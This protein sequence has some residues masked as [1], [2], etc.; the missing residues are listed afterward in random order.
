MAVGRLRGQFGICRD[1]VPFEP[2]TV[3]KTLSLSLVSCKVARR[4]I[5]P[6]RNARVKGDATDETHGR[7]H[8][9][10]KCKPIPASRAPQVTLAT[11]TNVSSM[12]FSPSE[13]V[14]EHKLTTNQNIRHPLE[15]EVSEPY[16]DDPRGH[17][18][19]SIDQI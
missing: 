3:W 17:S 8:R 11:D 7:Y 15:M 2:G 19:P 14:E 13:G 10:Q 4:V 18:Y 5:V 16:I 6:R 9:G 12:I 1:Q